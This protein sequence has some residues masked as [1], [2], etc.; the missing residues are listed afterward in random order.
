MNKNCKFPRVHVFGNVLKHA[1][2]L[3]VA[4][5]I[6]GFRW[7]ECRS[8]GSGRR[9]EELGTI[10]FCNPFSKS[11]IDVSKGDNHAKAVFNFN[12]GIHDEGGM[13]IVVVTRRSINL[14]DEGISSRKR[15]EETWRSDTHK[16]HD[17]CHED[18]FGEGW[19]FIR[20][21]VMM[22]RKIL[23]VGY[24]DCLIVYIFFSYFKLLEHLKITFW[25][26]IIW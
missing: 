4:A 6:I 14:G 20:R 8:N 7:R 13:S 19:S 3:R 26:E 23:H 22:R 2:I 17:F 15:A 11:T 12:S 1:T 5:I 9:G 18:D 21:I 24:I 25:H 10:P 16:F